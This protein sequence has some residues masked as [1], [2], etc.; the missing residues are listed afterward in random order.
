[1][2]DIKLF[3]YLQAKQ[4]VIKDLEYE[5]KLSEL[6]SLISRV[7]GN[8]D[9]YN[10]FGKTKEING[11][12]YLNILG[13]SYYLYVCK[14]QT[15]G[16]INPSFAVSREPINKLGISN[17]N[18]LT[19]EMKELGSFSTEQQFLDFMEGENKHEN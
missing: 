9:F 16:Q 3:S 10:F 8:L 5:E 15:R 19:L 12:L 4:K 2:S 17:W 7:F 18:I 14:V 1:M 6:K 13:S 11:R